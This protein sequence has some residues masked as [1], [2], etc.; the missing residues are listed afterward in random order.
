MDCGVFTHLL[1]VIPP[2]FQQAFALLWGESVQG[3]NNCQSKLF[4]PSP[5]TEGWAQIDLWLKLN[6][7]HLQL[8]R[9]TGFGR[10]ISLGLVDWT[11][12][13]ILSGWEENW[14]EMIEKE[15]ERK[16]IGQ[17]LD[18]EVFLILRQICAFTER[19]LF[20]WSRRGTMVGFVPLEPN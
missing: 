4:Q 12:Q 11:H 3:L 20:W 15:R 10:G 9:R 16:S 1:S 8:R 19:I 18:S 6:K 2:L 14:Q 13:D 5:Q 7:W 17:R